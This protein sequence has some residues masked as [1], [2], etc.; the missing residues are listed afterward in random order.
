MRREL[1]NYFSNIGFTFYAKKINNIIIAADRRPLLLV[2]VVRV[3][4]A[5]AST[6]HG[7]RGR[8]VFRRPV[9]LKVVDPL[10]DVLVGQP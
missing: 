2:A 1:N 8:I 7:G 4:W 6:T 9:I 5:R 3:S 10:H